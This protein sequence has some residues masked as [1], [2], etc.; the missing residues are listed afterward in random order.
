MSDGSVWQSLLGQLNVPIGQSG[1][2]LLPNA[3]I[4]SALPI[5]S[6]P[7]TVYPSCAYN[8]HTLTSNP[9]LFLAGGYSPSGGV[10][11]TNAAT[12]NAAYTSTNA[13]TSFT[14]K[15][16]SVWASAPVYNAGAAY[17]LNGR[18]LL[19]GGQSGTAVTAY[20]SA[21]YSSADQGATWTM[22]TAN[23]TFG[24]RTNFAT[25]V[26]PGTNTVVIVGGSVNNN[27]TARTDNSI[28]ASTDSG[29][30]WTLQ[31][32]L[33]VTTLAG[34]CVFLYD[35]AA[36]SSAFTS[37][38]GTLLVFTHTMRLYRSYTMGASFDPTPSMV[39]PG[40]SGYQFVPF[41]TQYDATSTRYQTEIVADADNYLYAMAGLNV[42]DNG[43]YFSGDLGFTWYRIKQSNRLNSA[44][45]I[46][47]S[48]SCLGLSYVQS[49]SSYVKTL[50]LYGGVQVLFDNGMN[51][52]AIT[53][54]VDSAPSF[55]PATT[56]TAVSTTA[57]AQRAN[58]AQLWCVDPVQPGIQWETVTSSATMP[59][60][61]YPLCA[62]DVHQG[63][64]TAP[65][66]IYMYGG[67]VSS[68]NAARLY[69][70]TN[71]FQSI[72]NTSHLDT[73]VGARRMGSAAVLG[74]GNLVLLGGQT[75]TTAA[76][77]TS[78]VFLSS[79]KGA[80]FTKV[81]G[82]NYPAKYE[83]QVLSIPYTN[84]LVAIGGYNTAG[85]ETNDVWL[86]TDGQG[87]VW[88]QQASSLSVSTNALAASAVLYDS[89]FVN[90]SLYSSP[91]STILFFLEYSSGAYWTSNDLG[92]TWSTNFYYPMSSALTSASSI[93]HRDW[94]EC[95]SDHDSIIYCLG[96][97]NNPDEQTWAS[98]T[99]GQTFIPLQIAP[100]HMPGI[101]SYIQMM[102]A[103]Y[104]CVA[105][106]FGIN[107]QTGQLTKQLVVYGYYTYLT[108]GTQW[109]A[110]VGTLTNVP[111]G[112]SVPMAPVATLSSSLPVSAV[113]NGFQ[114]ACAYNVHARNGV[115]M[116]YGG[117]FNLSDPTTLNSQFTISVNS[118]ASANATSLYTY[119]L[120][121]VPY[122]AAGGL[123]LLNNGAILQFGGQTSPTTFSNTVYSSSSSN[124][125][126]FTQ[127]AN[128]PWSPR[129]GFITCTMPYSNLVLVI[130]GTTAAGNVND[131]WASSDGLGAAWSKPATTV[132]WSE[133]GILAGT[134]VFLYDGA[135]VPSLGSTQA[136]STL[137]VFTQTNHYYRSVTGGAS[138]ITQP[139][140]YTPLQPT[141]QT[142]PWSSQFDSSKTRYGI[143]V[144]ADYDNH[145]YAM[146][147]TGVWDNTMWWSGDSG[148]LWYRMTQINTLN[149]AYFIQAS[150][151]CLGLNYVRNPA[152]TGGYNKTLV[153]YAG[154]IQ[155]DDGATKVG[156]LIITVA[157]PVV[158][159]PNNSTALTFNP[160]AAAVSSSAIPRSSSAAATS[161]P[162]TTSAPIAT[163]APLTTSTPPS[164]TSIPTTTSAP[165]AA[166]ST[167][168]PSATSA[169][170]TTSA[171]AVTSP[172]SATSAA[173][174]TSTPTPSTTSA[175]AVA[176]TSQG[177]VYV[178]PVEASDSSSS[179][180]SGGAI[181]GIV[182]GSVVGGMLLCF[183]LVACFVAR[184]RSQNQK[185]DPTTQP[186]YQSRQ[187][188]DD[189]ASS[190]PEVEM[191]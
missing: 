9:L 58:A 145:L 45:F 166:T 93:T 92:R 152:A 39:A 62:S 25:C 178:P 95:T 130:G 117:V 79:D 101:S 137:L 160:R 141:Y 176:A 187:T 149:S 52:S 138:W 60:A 49:G 159:L 161:A 5:A 189:D 121:S 61:E 156:A 42:F 24:A 74:N 127:V 184:V 165:A 46:Q 135:Q 164:A 157:D 4:A 72:T 163:S 57:M 180:L 104:G 84:W 64:P 183:M 83:A 76:T 146:A 1:Y 69:G 56:G 107:S 91:N 31:G 44:Q 190:A 169:R 106:Q 111:V 14:L 33:P 7:S 87:A 34:S 148:F 172:P 70:T 139:N 43:L 170:A 114:T 132:P 47:A 179:G 53:I 59:F 63:V 80:T 71:G 191:H 128:A 147:G 113:T 35:N 13:G 15:S 153:L 140:P 16:S 96:E 18:L 68:A 124:G 108:D 54:T 105:T 173:A 2:G 144:V 98:F 102:W 90:P 78:D 171:P 103:E 36:V 85:A 100:S 19:I 17:L 118:F 22:A 29:V 188:T 28:Y 97:Y 26:M 186:S 167:P 82:A 175:P 154:N 50:T 66:S 77:A 151:S 185:K 110:L 136:Y 12:I 3:T 88:T 6:L 73:T 115:M 32:S 120:N 116:A 142:A 89:K 55:I 162:L 122:S 21:V 155:F 119:N 150:T 125:I 30:T 129:A 37:T 168:A 182:V 41:S 123:T 109:S 81:V 134:C 131:I 8:L 65:T 23:A 181:A 174:M 94:Q 177:S 27:G 158:F 67:Y 75:G 99:K 48:T 38:T 20:S 51:Y 126:A 40:P 112:K 86:S 133:A 11:A 10:N 143:E